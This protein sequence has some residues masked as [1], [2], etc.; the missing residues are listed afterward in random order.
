MR[1]PPARSRFFF[2]ARALKEILWPFE[3]RIFE[4]WQGSMFASDLRRSRNAAR[5]QKDR[6]LSS[7]SNGRRVSLSAQAKELYIL[8]ESFQYR[9]RTAHE[10]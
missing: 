10:N 5:T 3:A 8:A 9:N 1:I 4:F 7:Y 6:S 2:C